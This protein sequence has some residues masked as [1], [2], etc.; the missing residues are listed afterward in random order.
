MQQLLFFFSDN[1][2]MRAVQI[3]LVVLAVIA[4]LLVCFA[5]KDI[6]LRTHSFLYQASCVL[7]VACLPIVGYVLYLLVRPAR[8][9]MDREMADRV[10]TLVKKVDTLIEVQRSL[11]IAPSISAAASV[12]SE[13]IIAS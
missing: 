5:T 6:L 3:S 7:L 1:P 11:L 12:P 9:V 10:E 4:V 8:T 13:E 2:A